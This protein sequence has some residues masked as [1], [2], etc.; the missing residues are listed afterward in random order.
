MVTPIDVNKQDRPALE[1]KQKV[2]KNLPPSKPIGTCTYLLAPDQMIDISASL[3]SQATNVLFEGDSE[4]VS[5][6][7][8]ILDS[9]RK[10]LDK[11]SVLSS[12]QCPPDTRGDLASH[13]CLVGG[14]TMFKGFKTRLFN[15]LQKLVQST[16]Y[17]DLTG[18]K[19]KFAF[20]VVPI[21]AAYLAWLGTAVSFALTKH[22]PFE[23]ICLIGGLYIHYTNLGKL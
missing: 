1:P 21:P 16:Q 14:N 20:I 5:I 23:D 8:L 12:F 22:L 13:I 18:L 4:G 15:E 19:D 6:A 11:S 17:Q 10:V 7:T 9:L 2:I 3:R